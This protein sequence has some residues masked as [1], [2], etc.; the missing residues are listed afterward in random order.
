M[1]K[2][3]IIASWFFVSL[4][5][6]LPTLADEPAAQNAPA[7]TCSDADT[8]LQ[9]GAL[10]L[11]ESTYKALLEIDPQ[12][13]C[14]LLGLRT[15][16]EQRCR[17]AGKM[18]DAGDPDGARTMY[19]AVLE[20]YPDLPCAIEGLSALP[21]AYDKVKGF[22][23]IG[24]YEKAWES[25]EN[26]I[27]A[28]PSDSGLGDFSTQWWAL[29][30]RSILGLEYCLGPVLVILAG[31][32]ICL[33][34]YQRRSLRLDVVSFDSGTTPLKETPEKTG[35]PGSLLIAQFEEELTRIGSEACKMRRPDLIDVPLEAPAFPTSIKGIP[36]QLGT[37]WAF[38]IKLIPPK[39]VEIKGTLKYSPQQGAG[40]YVKL[41]HK[42]TSR[43][44]GAYTV[45]QHEVDPH[46]SPNSGDPGISAYLDL[47]EF[48][49]ISAY[50]LILQQKGWRVM[51][52]L[53]GKDRNMRRMFGT[54]NARSYY[55]TTRRV[56]PLFEKLRGTFLPAAEKLTLRKEIE[57]LSLQALSCD[58]RNHTARLYLAQVTR[59]EAVIENI[60]LKTKPTN[61][62]RIAADYYLGIRKTI[63]YIQENNALQ[64]EQL[65][66]EARRFLKEGVKSAEKMRRRR[67]PAASGDYIA[68]LKI[69]YASV[70]SWSRTKCPPWSN[71]ARM[72]EKIEDENH[73]SGKVLYNLA[74]HYS[75]ACMYKLPPG[76]ALYRALK[77]L[78]KSLRA[79][80]GLVG[81][82]EDDPSLVCLRKN[83]PAEVSELIKKYTPPPT[84]P[85]APAAVPPTEPSGLE[86]LVGTENAEH[87]KALHI[88]SADD[89]LRETLKKKNR[90]ALAG[91]CFINEALLLHWAKAV[92]MI[93]VRGIEIGQAA[94][95]EAAGVD[96]LAQLGVWR[97]SD[98]AE[99]HDTL[100]KTVQ[101][102]FPEIAPPDI[103]TL[104]R[105]I[106]SAKHIQ[107]Q[108]EI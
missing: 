29:W 72:I 25:L 35:Q 88:I 4:T 77:Y 2:T 40:L 43:L 67:K 94:L 30:K 85:E 8:Y 60:R 56:Y 44:W 36:E 18:A 96:S 76:D 68:M 103:E 16:A 28:T 99:L 74:C 19:T 14:A 64:R 17:M 66:A 101:G 47:V 51:R 58:R 102:R 45:W 23:T 11:A 20:A 39:V 86:S 62:V 95:L 69:P 81:Y 57:A 54:E 5:T 42:S 15:V 65:L 93:C 98:I 63:E 1:K 34:A 32:W 7:A 82:V 78:E 12:D 59:E 91:K 106:V 61:P 53:F 48:A 90:K 26:A 92:E 41:V 97:Q 100:E 13:N 71:P 84:A 49:A 3:W 80:P 79:M 87:L 70:L 24:D 10:G 75:M 83:K 33:L 22:A 73:S 52:W 50:W 37:L 108:V 55:I 21:T 27:E 105:W 6:G 107:T 104:T 89:L 38:V 31:I 46:Y 9:S